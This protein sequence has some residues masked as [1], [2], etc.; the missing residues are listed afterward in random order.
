MQARWTSPDYR[1][2]QVDKAGKV[3]TQASTPSQLEQALTVMSNW[4]SSHS[5]P[6]HIFK[7]RLGRASKK[8]DK[9]AVVVQRL[10]RVPSIIKKLNRAQTQTMKLSQ[11]QDIG[12]CRAVL[13][14]VS[15]VRKLSDLYTNK[16]KSRGLKHKKVNE[17][18][19]IKNPKPD[20]YRSIHLIY[21]Y[22]SD[23]KSTYD[24]LLVEIQI[25]SRIQHAW[26]TAV[27][28]VDLFTKQAIKSNEGRPEWI[29]FFKL[30][31]SAFAL[32]EGEAPV[33]GTPTDPRELKREI[34]KRVGELRVFQ[35]ME[36]WT[37]AITII[38]PK[39][40]ELHFFL[41]VLDVSEQD[42]ERLEIRGYLKDAER[43]AT[44]QYLEAEKNQGTDPNK[45]VVL[46]A[47]D[48][49]DELRKAYPNY[50]IDTSHFLEY[51][52]KYLAN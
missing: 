17:K 31:S 9:E 21:R 48:S 44:D 36:K 7:I 26:A 32:M 39:M 49:I 27:E 20:G 4:R 24:G 45:D 38:E 3:L 15:L 18:D 13:S 50:F 16:R 2:S 51:L 40:K 29:E 14:N 6:M 11:M 25:R 19:Y 34:K 8:I 5:Y 28:T 42:K 30:V 12:G 47:A 35:K 37:K 10:K 33:P 1:K 23:K 41:L 46:V 22:K 52:K 43:T